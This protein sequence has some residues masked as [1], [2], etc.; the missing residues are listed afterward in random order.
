MIISHKHKFIFF[1]NTKTAGSSIEIALSKYCGEH[2]V[3]T[4]LWPNE[5]ELRLSIGGVGQQNHQLPLEQHRFIHRMKIRFQGKSQM[6]AQHAKASE[7]RPYVTP[8]IWNSYYKFVVARNPWDRMVS[9]YYFDFR[10]AEKPNA[11]NYFTRKKLARFN[12]RGWGMYT[13]ND[14]PV[15]DKICRF[16]NLAADLEEVRLAIGLPEPLS[17]PRAKGEFR[18]KKQGYRELLTE[19]Q[20]LRIG[21]IFKKEIDHL[22]YQF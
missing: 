7:M 1:K 17:L 14:I 15:V 2:D 10:K 20:S 8:E 12:R 6:F 16:E 11:S 3:L 4:P 21:K 5:E 19:E 9:H 18:P 13:I 22:G